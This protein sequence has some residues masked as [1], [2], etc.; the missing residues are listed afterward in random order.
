MEEVSLGR[1]RIHFGDDRFMSLLFC[2]DKGQKSS[3]ISIEGGS[4]EQCDT[5]GF[6]TCCKENN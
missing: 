4:V 5:V 6:L 1:P 3:I 2:K